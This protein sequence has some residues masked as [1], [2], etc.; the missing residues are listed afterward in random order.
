[1][2]RID[3]YISGLFWAAFVGGLLV[4]VTIFLAVDA[5]STMVN[6]Q[7]VET[8]T[9]L[10]Y[11]A[12]MAPDI[13]HKML[14]VASVLG[15]VLTLSTLNRAGELVA[16]FASGMSLLR[17]SAS[18]LVWVS[19]LSVVSYVMSDRLLPAMSR[20]KNYVFYHE[21]KKTP[22]LFSFVKTDRIWYRSKN[23]IF[24]IKT[25]TPEASKAQGL[26]MYFFSDNW[27][28]LQMLT[29][30]EVEMKGKTWNLTGGSVTLFSQDSS[31]PL[32]SQFKS[33]ILPMDED[34]QD[35]VNTGQ[36]SEMLSQTELAKFIS[37][38]KEAG[39]DTVRYE[40][41][42]HSK[43]GFALAGLVMALLGIPFAV[44]RARSGGI[45]MNLGICLGLVFFYW[46]LYNSSLTLGSHG[47][48]PPLAAAW[49]PNLLMGGF[50]FFLLRR[51][52]R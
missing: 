32:T 39:L 51:L 41:D 36:T 2:N 13:M 22:G 34:S 14:P 44:G 11:Y 43:F 17:V 38:N 9:L 5:M 18:M 48:I 49:T 15:V 52:K 7:G 12:A 16:L 6:Y 28:L 30:K 3:R 31:F 45:M 19:M 35:L 10:R 33:K 37:K 42:Y 25:L 26:T 8:S 27:D 29:A 23:T 1:M 40:V 24:N 50:A 46:I 21:I 20:Q 47:Q 4:F